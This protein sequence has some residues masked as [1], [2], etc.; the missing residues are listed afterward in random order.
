MLKTELIGN[1]T[2]KPETRET[3]SGK[4]VT[5]FNLAVNLKEDKSEFFT[6]NAWGKL[7]ELCAKYLDKGRKVYVRG[8]LSVSLYESHGH[9]KYQLTITA[10]DVEFLTPRECQETATVQDGAITTEDDWTPVQGDLPF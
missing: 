10:D 9:T 8:G 1:L 4:S 7:G 2:N 5:H 3:N 6:I